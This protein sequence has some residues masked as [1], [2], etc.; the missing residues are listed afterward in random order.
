MAQ[1]LTVSKSISEVYEVQLKLTT[2]STPPPANGGRVR[3]RNGNAGKRLPIHAV[4]HLLQARAG[5]VDPVR[6][7]RPDRAAVLGLLR[8]Y[9]AVARCRLAVPERGR[10]LPVHVGKAEAGPRS[11][12]VYGTRQQAADPAQNTA[13][14]GR[15]WPHLV[16]QGEPLLPVL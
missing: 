3:A 8:H 9:A 14:A 2:F 15:P 1:G 11:G 4:Q 6:L 12:T 16:P 7:Y 5:R 10:H 13:R